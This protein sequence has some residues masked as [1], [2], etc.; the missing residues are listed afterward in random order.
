MSC[1]V[2]VQRTLHLCS[3][4][5][6]AQSKLKSVVDKSSPSGTLSHVVK[7][8]QL[9]HSEASGFATDNDGK[10]LALLDYTNL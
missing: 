7:P 5:I 1:E 8:R 10:R 4:C 9:G 3:S 6:D 2:L